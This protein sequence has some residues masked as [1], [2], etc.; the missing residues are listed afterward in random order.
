MG[1]ASVLTLTWTGEFE[2][3][4]DGPRFKAGYTYYDSHL[5]TYTDNAKIE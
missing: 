4:D 2:E 5:A 1:I 3:T